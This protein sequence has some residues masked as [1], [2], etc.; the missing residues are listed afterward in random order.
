MIISHP[1]PHMP[2]QGQRTRDSERSRGVPRRDAVHDADRGGRE[3]GE[4]VLFG[5]R[6]EVDFEVSELGVGAEV[7]AEVEVA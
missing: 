2:Q 1:R 4:D 6:A 5:E 7:Y 3:H